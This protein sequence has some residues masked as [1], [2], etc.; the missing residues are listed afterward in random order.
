[1]V[2]GNA[3]NIQEAWKPPI[4]PTIKINV[5]VAWKDGEYASA[6]IARDCNGICCGAATRLGRSESV[7]YAEADGF[8]LATELSLWLNITPIEIEGDIQ[9]VVEF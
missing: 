5:E 8:L 2:Q 7:T 4:S 9:V 1:M 3:D 6:A